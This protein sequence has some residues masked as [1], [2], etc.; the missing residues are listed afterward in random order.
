MPQ[1]DVFQ[2]IRSQFERNPFPPSGERG[3]VQGGKVIARNRDWFVSEKPE[4][5]REDYERRAGHRRSGFFALPHVPYKPFAGLKHTEAYNLIE[6]QL[7]VSAPLV[8]RAHRANTKVCNWK[9]NCCLCN[10]VQHSV[11]MFLVCCVHI[12]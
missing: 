8:S 7:K 9:H 1:T 12:L 2:Q 4:K 5:S 6:D 11:D 3:A 10:I